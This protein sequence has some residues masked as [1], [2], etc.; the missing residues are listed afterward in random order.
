[1]QCINCLHC[2]WK[3]YKKMLIY[4]AF[5]KYSDPLT[6]STFCSFPLMS[7]TSPTW[8]TYCFPGNRPKSLSFAW[9]EDRENEDGGRAAFWEF[10][11]DRTNMQ[12]LENKID[13]L[14]GRLNYQ[15]DI[16]TVIS[17]ASWSRGWMTTLSTYSWLVIRCIGRIELLLI[18]QGVADNVYL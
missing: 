10:E 3:Q 13:D 5:G 4:S 15:R 18:W 16:K 9:R 6:F 2:L 8:R 12:T 17:Y 11:G 1:M 7:P 14:R